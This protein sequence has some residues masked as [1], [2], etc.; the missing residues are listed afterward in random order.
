MT[1]SYVLGKRLDIRYN[2]WSLI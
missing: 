2:T 1:R